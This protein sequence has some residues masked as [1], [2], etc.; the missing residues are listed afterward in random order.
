MYLYKQIA[1]LI[2]VDIILLIARLITKSNVKFTKFTIQK[3]NYLTKNKTNKC[4]KKAQ[5]VNY[6]YSF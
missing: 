2:F 3:H 6:Y 4:N 1:I 5:I